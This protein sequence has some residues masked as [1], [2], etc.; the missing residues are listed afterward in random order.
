MLR[1]LLRARANGWPEP[2]PPLAPAHVV[3]KWMADAQMVGDD[4]NMLERTS[5]WMSLRLLPHLDLVDFLSGS[6]QAYH[7]VSDL[8]RVGDWDAL[9]PLVQPTCLESMVEHFDGSVRALPTDADDS[10]SIISAVLSSARVVEPCAAEGIAAGTCHLDV[11][12]CSLQGVTLHD[13]QS[14]D[15]FHHAPPRLQ[16]STW[17][18]EG[19]AGAT[20]DEDDASATAGAWRVIDIDWKVWEVGSAN[21]PCS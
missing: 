17:S 11:R 5:M 1:T 8:I 6:R 9:A 10:M 3:N 12:F 2:P 7:V 4:L 15:P 16:E 21:E 18:F 20:S 19:V 14:A 13:L